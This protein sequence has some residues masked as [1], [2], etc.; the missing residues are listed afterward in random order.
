MSEFFWLDHGSS[1]QLRGQILKSDAID[2]RVQCPVSPD[3][4]PRSDRALASR[5]NPHLDVEVRHSKRDLMMIWA[6]IAHCLVHTELLAEIRSAGFT[7]YSVRP[8]TVRFRDGFL[9]HEYQRLG[10]RGWGGLARPE[11][12][13]KQVGDCKGCLHRRW[14]AVLDPTQLIDRNQWNGDDCFIVWPLPNFIFVS[15]RLAEFLISSKVRSC[16]P[17]S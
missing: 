12:G 1:E 14:S 2:E 6:G 3:H 17:W 15:K 16:A 13:V 7:G 11:S 4:L 9:S 5:V 10:I 8:A